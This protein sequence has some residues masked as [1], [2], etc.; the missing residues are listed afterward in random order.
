MGFGTCRKKHVRHILLHSFHIRNRLDRLVNT[1]T[2]SGEDCLVNSEAAGGNRNHSAV[3]RNFVT[4]SN[5]DDISW[6]KFGCVYTTDLA[7][8]N[9]LSFIRRIF[10][11]SLEILR[12]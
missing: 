10:L 4:D 9:D 8:T 5:R 3:C 12:M 7:R 2:F 6:D 1:G 11:E